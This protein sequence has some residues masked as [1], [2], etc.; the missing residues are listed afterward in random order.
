[1]LR[2]IEGVASWGPSICEGQDVV[3]S[4]IS[5]GRGGRARSPRRYLAWGP[6]VVSDGTS[7]VC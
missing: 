3:D 7:R 2:D 1:M 6:G 5:Q 4:D